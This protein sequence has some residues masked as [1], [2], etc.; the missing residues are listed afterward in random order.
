MQVI[1]SSNSAIRLEKKSS[2]LPP[3]LYMDP[4][5]E[6]LTLDQFELL[7]LDRLQLLRQI[8]LLKARGFE[9]RELNTKIR[10]VLQTYLDFLLY[11]RFDFDFI[12]S[13][14]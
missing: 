6:E 2:S 3:T 7:S 13:R 10:E 12:L 1:T 8:E 4:P 14:L 9:E 5:T 11:Y